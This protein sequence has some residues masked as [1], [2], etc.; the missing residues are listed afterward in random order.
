MRIALNDINRRPFVIWSG[1]HCAYW[2]PNAQGYT[3]EQ[4]EAAIYDLSTA[5]VATQH[6]GPEKKIAF[7]RVG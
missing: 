3:T 2:R 1:E 6:C 4:N 7:I 5:I